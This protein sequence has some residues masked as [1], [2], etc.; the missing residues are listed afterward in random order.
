MTYVGNIEGLGKIISLYGGFDEE[1]RLFDE[2]GYKLVTAQ[3]LAFAK[4]AA[5]NTKNLDSFYLMHSGSWVREGVLYF[6]NNANT[7]IVL[8][9]NSLILDNLDEAVKLHKCG[10]NYTVADKVAKECLER[11]AKKDASVF[12]VNDADKEG[13]VGPIHT[14]CF[15]EIGITAWLFGN[16]SEDYGK[17]LKS[18]F[19]KINEVLLSFDSI[20]YIDAQAKPYAKQGWVE[21]QFSDFF[22]D[23]VFIGHRRCFGD[24]DNTQWMRACG[25]KH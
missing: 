1:M 22:S 2:D 4:M 6:P 13:I 19:G 11:V 12:V 25:V 16:K 24:Y 9:R 18:E 21:P 8:V 7:R 14:N 23:F 10:K 17:S 20:S 3:D 5:E 15:S